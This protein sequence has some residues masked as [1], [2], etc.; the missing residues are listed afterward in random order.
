MKILIPDYPGSQI[1]EGIRS[2]S[3][4]NLSV[5]LAWNLNPILRIL[6][7][8]NCINKFY[9]IS[10]N[11]KT[12]W[13]LYSNEVLQLSNRNNYDAV[14]PFGLNSAYALTRFSTINNNIPTMLPNFEDFKIANNKLLTAKLANS[15]GIATPKTFYN[16]KR[17]DL[18]S[19]C[20]EIEFPMVVKS[21][22]GTG[23]LNG[24]RYVYTMEQLFQLGKNL[25]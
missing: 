8:S 5:D 6:R 19:I 24:I 21:C 3:R 15:I 7:N 2:L 9:K 11:S 4:K 22:T 10:N 17:E 18:K 23:V 16:T 13:H 1:L 14:I 20:K 25:I 12:K